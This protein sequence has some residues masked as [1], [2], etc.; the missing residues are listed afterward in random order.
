MNSIGTSGAGLISILKKVSPLS[1]NRIASVLYRGPAELLTNLPEQTAKEIAELL[2]TAGLDCLAVDETYTFEPGDA[3]HEVALVIRDFARMPDVLEQIMLILGV[4]VETA[5]KIVC[6]SPTVL[7]G[8]ISK[9][10]VQALLARFAPLGVELDV[11]RPGEALFDVF[12]G[13]TTALNRQ[14]V[15][16]L[17]RDNKIPLLDSKNGEQPLLAVELPREQ[18]DKLWERLKRTS[19][20]VRIVNRDF[21][22][23]DLRLD[24]ASNSPEMMQYLQTSTG[25]PEKVAQKVPH[26]T[27]LIL[28]QNIRFSDLAAHM[29]QIQLLGGKASG[30]LLVFQTFSLEIT[31]VGDHKA[32]TNAVRFITGLKEDEALEIV[33]RTHKLGE[34]LAEPLTYPQA[35]WLQTELG[36]AGTD[37]HLVIL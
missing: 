8:G 24:Q 15:L 26:K 13:E 36:K 22:R 1:E 5:R 18:A 6:T 28:Q 16:R 11:S 32:S 7:V 17:L 29:E 2:H 12:L 30:H 27:P 37:S 3:D 4:D 31:K 9:N 14:Q 19:Y 25:M 20:P 23:F 34:P 21:Q 33:T 35:L 10:T